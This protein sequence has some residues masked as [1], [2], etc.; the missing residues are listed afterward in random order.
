MS[1]K[2]QYIQKLQ[3]LSSFRVYLR[4]STP[5]HCFKKYPNILFFLNCNLLTIGRVPGCP[6][7]IPLHIYILTMRFIHWKFCRWRI[8][9]MV[10]AVFGL[11]RF[12]G[13]VT[14]LTWKRRAN[15]PITIH[16]QSPRKENQPSFWKNSPMD[17][18]FKF[19]FVDHLPGCRLPTS[20]LEWFGAIRCRL[21]S[22]FDTEYV[23]ETARPKLSNKKSWHSNNFLTQFIEENEG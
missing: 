17:G 10:G 1:V 16:S 20:V 6:L 18:K 3:K 11:P 23:K 8:P 15:Q 4:R 22:K 5:S 21:S 13:L 12:S 7:S 9:L 2:T 14:V 19:M